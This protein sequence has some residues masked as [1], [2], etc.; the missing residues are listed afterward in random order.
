MQEENNDLLSICPCGQSN[1]CFNSKT[2]DF[3]QCFTCGLTKSFDNIEDLNLPNLYKDIAIGNWIPFYYNNG[4]Y[5]VYLDGTSKE[6]AKY[7]YFER[8]ENN[9]A[10]VESKK[11][12][13]RKDFFSLLNFLNDGA[14]D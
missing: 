11:T 12:F 4:N 6:D 1:D 9:Q 13:D 7:V 14:I 10:I 8:D 5:E 3:G 2:V